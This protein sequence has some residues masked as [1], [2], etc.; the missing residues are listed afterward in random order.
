MCRPGLGLPPF[1]N[2]EIIYPYLLT[3]YFNNQVQIFFFQKSTATHLI[4]TPNICDIHYLPNIS[5]YLLHKPSGQDPQTLPIIHDN[6]PTPSPLISCGGLVHNIYTHHLTLH[7][8]WS[9]LLL[10][11]A[12]CSNLHRQTPSSKYVHLYYICRCCGSGE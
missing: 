6:E 11:Y 12:F 9:Q 10:G 4:L 3:S 1:S 8:L 5:L 2:E 7:R